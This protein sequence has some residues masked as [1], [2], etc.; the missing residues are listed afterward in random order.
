MRRTRIS[1][2][3][4]AV[5][6]V[7][8]L[9]AG[10][11]PW[12]SAT[13]AAITPPAT[14]EPVSG[15]VNL[16]FS[17]G[18]TPARYPANSVVR[19]DAG[20]INFVKGCVPGTEGQGFPDFVQASADLYIVPSGRTFR[21]GDTLSDALGAPNTVWGGIGGT[22]LWE[23]LAITGAAGSAE[24]LPSGTY[25]V[26]VDEC[27]N[28]RWDTGQDSVVRDAFVVDIDQEVPG[29]D[30]EIEE[31][32]ALKARAGRQIGQVSQVESVF[33]QMLA[34]E[35]KSL[36]ENYLSVGFGFIGGLTSTMKAL[37]GLIDPSSQLKTWGKTYIKNSIQKRR[38]ALINLRDDPPDPNFQQFASPVRTADAVAAPFP[39]LDEA[40]AWG[41]VTDAVGAVEEAFVRALE[42]YQGAQAVGN[43]AWAA[44][45]ARS[46][47]E[48]ASLHAEL[49]AAQP[50]FVQDL[51]DRYGFGGGTVADQNELTLIWQ[52]IAGFSRLYDN[53]ALWWNTGLSVA[54]TEAAIEAF[55]AEVVTTPPSSVDAIVF[56]LPG[57]SAAAVADAE[58]SSELRAWVDAAV[59]GVLAELDAVI[60]PLA[61]DP[62][63]TISPV[64][65]AAAGATIT[66][67]VDLPIDYVP[68]SIRWD[69]DGDGLFDDASGVS[70]EWVVPG[71]VR[72][73]V[74][75]VVAV[76][77]TG[78][79]TADIAYEV[80]VPVAGNLPPTVELVAPVPVV[81][82]PGATTTLEVGVADPEGGPVSVEWFIDGVATG[83]TGTSYDVV[84]PA[85]FYGQ[86]DVVATATDAAGATAI[87]IVPVSVRSG[88][89]DDLDG[90]FAVPGPDC[91]D[92]GVF[93]NPNVAE[94]VGNGIDDDC[95][96]ATGDDG[97]PITTSLP[98]LRLFNG[99]EG[100]RYTFELSSWS[101]PNRFR[102]EAF[103]VTVDWGDG[104]SSTQT[105]SGETGPD[106][107]FSLSH[108]YVD[109]LAEGDVRWCVS[110]GSDPDGCGELIG[111][112]E[113]DNE[114]P[115]VGAADLRTWS[116]D[117]ASSN[118]DQCLGPPNC[119]GQTPAGNGGDWAV[120]A[121]GGWATTTANVNDYL[122]LHSPLQLSEGG[123]GRAM[124][125]LGVLAPNGDDD[126]IGLVVGYEPGDL[127]GS[128]G[129]EDFV[130]FEWLGRSRGI[131]FGE[132]TLFT[133]RNPNAVDQT[134][135]NDVLIDTATI[136]RTR[137]PATTYERAFNVVLDAIDPAGDPVNPL[138]QD[139]FGV[140]E[141][142]VLAFESS[143][144]DTDTSGRWL[145]RA[146]DRSF[147]GQPTFGPIKGP[148]TFTVDYRPDRL[149]MWTAN[150]SLVAD[151]ARAMRPVIRS[152]RAG[153]VCSPGLRPVFVRRARPPNW[154]SRSRRAPPG[155]SR[156]RSPTPATTSGPP[157]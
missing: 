22:F 11:L 114:P 60:N 133:C 153:W 26:V 30:Y 132:S 126:N 95:D 123:Y 116:E 48:L 28:G 122:V 148:Y 68:D 70:P 104:T 137:G 90:F 125:E 145:Q 6:A 94:R 79:L 119:D 19:V 102:N 92:G 23:P 113:I 83:A 106:T 13:V 140:D 93:I 129:D 121:E 20:N 3:A 108:R 149:R 15:A 44:R 58:F 59:P 75:Y 78:G 77:V 117:D 84:V 40:A 152:R 8:A 127:L 47:D 98:G 135:D 156:C 120:D 74:P 99:T 105:V 25:D 139:A 17:R 72:A 55:I 37:I 27:Q 36:A 147:T 87:E 80:V 100:D 65:G 43:V 138:C 56:Q 12:N 24:G 39:S 52:S 146:T 91:D 7:L 143:D 34:L 62:T 14:P 46:L 29:F 124:V 96:P 85:G 31:F 51:V 97:S 155:R 49:T 41:N 32:Q 111:A 110:N 89:D 21:T 42:R 150:G 18:G 1:I 66:L 103:T 45:H 61:A 9:L 141:L 57:L 134:D 71:N 142:E 82:A 86:L 81:G 109:E 107:T 64:V 73:G 10:L 131:Q 112:I 50:A 101:H 5:L 2:I 4:S 115:F 69:L 35:A 53:N 151:V 76:E 144:L 154:S 136:S 130:D 54:E 16:L 67:S 63:V 33:V 88:V 38:A 118:P 157:S 128:T